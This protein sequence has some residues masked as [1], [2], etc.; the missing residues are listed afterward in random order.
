M[1]MKFYI[2][3]LSETVHSILTKFKIKF[4]SVNFYCIPSRSVSS[5][6]NMTIL[7]WLIVLGFNAT[8][9]AKVISWW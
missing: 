6:Q 2:K 8:L 1:I 5:F 7:G 4:F 9:K 3:F